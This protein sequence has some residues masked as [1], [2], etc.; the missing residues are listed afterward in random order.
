MSATRSKCRSSNDH[1]PVRAYLKSLDRSADHHERR[2]QAV[3][4]GFAQSR[5][6]LK[7]MEQGIAWLRS[8]QQSCARILGA[9]HV[10][11]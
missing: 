11:K 1:G 7:T 9:S 4:R 5:R 6:D 10:A 2:A 3:A 8:M